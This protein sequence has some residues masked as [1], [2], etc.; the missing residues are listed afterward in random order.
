MNKRED[1]LE[2]INFTGKVVEE[3]ENIQN[4]DV[5]AMLNQLLDMNE[6]GDLVYK[7]WLEVQN[8]KEEL[9]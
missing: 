8:K 9:K 4:E 2:Y 3:V 1:G 6:V 5:K 7:I